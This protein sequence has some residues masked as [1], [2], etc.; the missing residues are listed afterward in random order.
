MLI[1]RI[2]NKYKILLIILGIIFMILLFMVTLSKK[3]VNRY[4]RYEDKNDV[5]LYIMEYHELPRNYITRGTKEQNKDDS[6]IIGG[7]T[8]YNKEKKL[9]EFGIDEST[10]LRECDIKDENYY[11]KQLDDDN[12]RGEHRLVY[13]SNTDKVRVFETTDHYDNFVEITRYDIMPFH[14]ISIYVFVTYISIS[15]ILM[16]FIFIK[17]KRY[18][19]DSI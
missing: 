13:T 18:I 12:N 3:E 14:Y 2:I 6:V 8:F 1:K 5:A 11:Y 7:D 10:P 9:D 16:T 15:F 17:E 4:S 19:K